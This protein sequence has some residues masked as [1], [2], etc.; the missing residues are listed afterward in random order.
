MIA[1][2]IRPMSA[3]EAVRVQRERPNALFLAGGTHLLSPALRGRT[4]IAVSL[5]GLLP[6]EIRIEGKLLSIG[7]LATLQDLVEVATPREGTALGRGVQATAAAV[8]VRATAAAD[9]GALTRA[10][11]AAPRSTEPFAPEL[12]LLREAGLS[13]AS[14]NVR[15]RAT[16]GGNIAANRPTSC[17]IPALLALDARLR[18]AGGGS[19][20]LSDYLARPGAL[21]EAVEIP[22]RPGRAASYRRWART[23]GDLSGVAVAVSVVAES[24]APVELRIA[25]IGVREGAV[26][27]AARLTSIEAQF[28]GAPLPGRAEI[29]RAVLPLLAAE[30]DVRASAAYRRLRGSQL[31][32]EALMDAAREAQ[33]ASAGTVE[34]ASGGAADDRAGATNRGTGAAKDAG[35][36][37]GAR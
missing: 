29:E 11:R 3:A 4:M 28:T 1:E 35:T 34:G 21:I 19:L 23:E 30:S 26:S 27:A 14:R 37:G 33:R 22:L 17:L 5:E 20:L 8:A 2:F 18:L 13:M 31:I 32:A 25:A 16:V 10:D 36:A 7:A 9:L 15:N 6:R 24:G 12:A